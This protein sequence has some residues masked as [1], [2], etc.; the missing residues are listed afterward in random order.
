V[1]VDLFITGK[2]TERINEKNADRTM[3]LELPYEKF[4]DISS[5]EDLKKQIS[6][7]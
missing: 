1:K 6:D 7:F 5:V 3:L 2:S 4:K